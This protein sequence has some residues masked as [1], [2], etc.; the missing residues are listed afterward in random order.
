MSIMIEEE[1]NK[2]SLVAAIQ[3]TLPPVPSKTPP[4]PPPPVITPA[5]NIADADVVTLAADFLA[6]STKVQLNIILNCK[7]KP[8]DLPHLRGE[9]MDRIYKMSTYQSCLQPHPIQV[10][11]IRMI[12][13]QNLIHTRTW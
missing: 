10:M 6:L 1:T 13:N 8:L 11:Q 12:L 2:S 3:T 9:I 4:I 7:L 5:P